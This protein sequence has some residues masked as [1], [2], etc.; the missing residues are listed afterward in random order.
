MGKTMIQLGK[1]PNSPSKEHE[2]EMFEKYFSLPDGTQKS[3]QK[4]FIASHYLAFVRHIIKENQ[5]VLKDMPYEDRF[6]QGVIGLMTAI[7][8]FDIKK[9]F[10]FTSYASHYIFSSCTRELEKNETKVK[11]PSNTYFKLKNPDY[12]EVCK[13]GKEYYSLSYI[14]MDDIIK[15]ERGEGYSSL[16]NLFNDPESEENVYFDTNRYH[17]KKLIDSL[18]T[19]LDPLDKKIIQ[20]YYNYEVDR[21]Y[22]LAEISKIVG[23]SAEGVRQRKIKSITKLKYAASSILNTKLDEITCD[24]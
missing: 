1:L 12:K 11:I 22:D 4:Q 3:K 5:I 19:N 13:K 23:L 17:H 20:M 18:F 21:K 15:N 24:I 16:L 6:Q 10:R 7:D 9:G 2:Y 14:N 8:K